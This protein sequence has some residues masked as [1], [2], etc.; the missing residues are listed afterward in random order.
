MY[1]SSTSCPEPGSIKETE[2]WERNYTHAPSPFPPPE[3]H[4]SVLN[5]F[6]FQNFFFN[7]ILP[8]PHYQLCL[9]VFLTAS[10]SVYVKLMSP[11]L[12]SGD[13]LMELAASAYLL[14]RRSVGGLHVSDFIK[15]F[16]F[17]WGKNMKWKVK[18]NQSGIAHGASSQATRDSRGHFTISGPIS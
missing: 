7:I 9:S 13:N 17:Q 11:D 12:D 5:L 18:G 4:L 1:Q 14:F 6:S 15:C 16:L 2:M 10:L 8:F 3:P